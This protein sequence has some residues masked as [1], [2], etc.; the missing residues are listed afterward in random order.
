M[1]NHSGTTFFTAATGPYRDF[2]VPYIYSVTHHNDDA[3]VEI[4]LDDLDG[5]IAQHA[6]AMTF[7]DP[8]RYLL[9]E[10]RFSGSDGQFMRFLIEPLTRGRYVYIG[11]VDILV[12]DGGITSAHVNNAA[13][14]GLPYSNIQRP[15][16]RRLTGLHFSQ[17]DAY[18]PVQ[19]PAISKVRTAGDEELLLLLVEERGWP[20]PAG[21]FRPQHGIH[22]SPN[23]MAIIAAASGVPSW[24]LSRSRW[25]AYKAFANTSRWRDVLPHLSN[26]L[27]G[28]IARMEYEAAA[29]FG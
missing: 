15:G 26:T 2:I 20:L 11:D 27:Q 16:T 28:M 1:P 21:D 12:L 17:W 4:M 8:D 13:R 3:F 9:R 5:F 14:L 10:A 24:G 22:M 7:L 19:I 6:G 18:Y 29:S 23:R 25:R